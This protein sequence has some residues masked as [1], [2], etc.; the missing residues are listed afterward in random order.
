MSWLY[1][2]VLVEEYL[3]D[4]SLDGEQSALLSGKPTQLAYCA[5][6]KMTAFSRLSQ[7]GMTYKPLTESRGEELLTLYLAGFHAKTLAQLGEVTALTENDQECGEKW[8]GWLAKYDLNMS[9]WRTAQCSLLEDLNESLETLPRWGMTANGLLWEQP[10]LE[11]R[12]KGTESGL[13]RTPDTGAGGT[14]G[15]L[16][17]GQ[18]HRANGQSIQIRLVDQVNNPHLWPTPNA[19]DWKDSQTSGNRKSPGLGV[20]AH[21]GKTIDGGSLNPPWVEW[22]MGWPLGWTDLKPLETDKFRNVQQPLGEF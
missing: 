20:V 15:L 16:K 2:R 18:T 19:R 10:T 11:R 1:S 14:S 6:D 12:I 4:I 5:P 9:L 22:L 17:Q 21:V 13:W 8:R 7:F 3:G